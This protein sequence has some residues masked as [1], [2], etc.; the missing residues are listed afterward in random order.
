MMLAVVFAAYFPEYRLNQEIAAAKSEGLWLNLSEARTAIAKAWPSGDNAAVLVREAMALRRSK[1]IQNPEPELDDVLTGRATPDEKDLVRGYAVKN[2]ALLDL[3]RRASKMPRMDYGRPWEQGF[4]L[5]LPEYAVV[6]NG[7]KSLVAAAAVGI[8]PKENLLAAARL[9]VLTRQDPSLIAQMVSVAMGST[10]LR[11]A[12]KLG[13]GKEVDAA[14]GAPIDVRWAYAM[15]FPA[16]LDTA[17]R[18]GT[19]EWDKSMGVPSEGL[20]ERIKRAGPTHTNAALTVV[21]DF[22]EFWKAMPQDGTD[23]AAAIRAV[24]QKLPDVYDALARMS[25]AM[26]VVLSSSSVS[27]AV[28]ALQ[29]FETLRAAARSGKP[30]PPSSV[31]YRYK[32]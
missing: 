32:S 13:M 1:G 28:K 11:Q 18:V 5:L 27:E 20:W 3:Y 12:A 31:P 23:Y 30:L 29:K 22:R 17:R 19:P 2:E 14:L 10:A 4:A 21:H 16:C 26:G 6:K 7:G 25:P 9:S 24:D 15:E 8:D